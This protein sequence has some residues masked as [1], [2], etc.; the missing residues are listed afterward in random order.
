MSSFSRRYPPEMIAFLWVVGLVESMTGNNS[1]PEL[2]KLATTKS[3][4]TSFPSTVENVTWAPAAQML[5]HY[6]GSADVVILALVQNAKCGRLS[7]ATNKCGAG[8]RVYDGVSNHMYVVISQLCNCFL[9]LS[10][11]TWFCSIRS[12]SFSICTCG[13]ARFRNLDDE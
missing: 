12:N 13:S 11:V 4:Q 3:R 5:R 10:K 7:L 1:T 9:R 6:P 8:I 2:S